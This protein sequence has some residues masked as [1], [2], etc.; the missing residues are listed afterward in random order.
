LLDLSNYKILVVDDEPD[1]LEFISAVLED[2]GAHVITA[3]NG[4]HALEIAKLEKPDLVTL[5]IQMPQKDGG[6][7][8]EE[9]RGDSELKNIPVCIISGQ[10]ELRRLIYQRIVPPPEGYLDKPINE[11]NLLLNIRKI[12]SSL[13]R[14]SS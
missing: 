3:R 5:D 8:F 4:D 12:L 13:E 6:E 7:V 2:N 9:M 14:K 11:R 1:M 10:P